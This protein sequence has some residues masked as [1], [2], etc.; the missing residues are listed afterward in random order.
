[1]AQHG[2][3]PSNVAPPGQ[4]DERISQAV[5]NVKAEWK[6]TVATGDQQ[7]LSYE[8]EMGEMLQRSSTT[9]IVSS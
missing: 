4:N 8:T 7:G 2:A 9:C 3:G 1:M 6:A 5:D